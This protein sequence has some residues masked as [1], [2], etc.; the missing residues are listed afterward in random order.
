MTCTGQELAGHLLNSEQSLSLGAVTL[1]RLWLAASRQSP[2]T[3]QQDQNLQQ[4]LAAALP[5]PRTVLLSHIKKLL[6]QN[7]PAD[8]ALSLPALASMAGDLNHTTSLAGYLEELGYPAT[9]SESAFREV[10]QQLE[11]VDERAVAQALGMMARTHKDLQAD[12]HGIHASLAAALGGLG[13]AASQ[14]AV[15]FAPVGKGRSRSQQCIG[16]EF[17]ISCWHVSCARPLLWIS[18]QYSAIL[19]ADMTPMSRFL[20]ARAQTAA[21]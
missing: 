11:V 8:D 16:L 21:P 14:P 10:L 12:P 9:A 18:L 17:R 7:S 6:F 19:H 2:L 20:H 5:G 13:G 3:R 4:L 1:H 15:S